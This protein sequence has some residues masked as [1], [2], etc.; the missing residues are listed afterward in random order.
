[1][2]LEGGDVSYERSS[3]VD[4][5]RRLK[6]RLLVQ[7]LNWGQGGKVRVKVFATKVR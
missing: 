6:R 4:L 2:A 3:P 5:V 1:M 7:G